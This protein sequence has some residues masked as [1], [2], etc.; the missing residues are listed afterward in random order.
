MLNYAL[1]GAGR[2]A[3]QHLLAAIY[4]KFN[5]VALVDIERTKCNNLLDELGL[6]ETRVYT[7]YIEMLK[8]EDLDLVAVATPNGTHFKIAKEVLLKKIN[9][10]IE[11]PVTISLVDLDNLVKLK[12]K[13]KLKVGVCHQNRFNKSIQK[14]KRHIDSGDLGKINLISAKVFWYRD[15]DYYSQSPWRGSVEHLDGALL[16][17][18]IHNIDLLLWFVNSNVIN[19][20]STTRNFIHPEIEMEDFGAAIIEFENSSVGLFEA[21][22]AAF[23]RN[24]EESLYIFAEKGTI[25][26]GG[27]SVN[28]IEEWRLIEMNEPVED[29]KFHNSELPENIYGN[30]HQEIYRDMMFSVLNDSEPY[31]TLENAKKSL[32]LILEIYGKQKI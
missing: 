11:K 27:Q 16:N 30:G 21:T 4:N 29:L 32:E 23:P 17:Q 9:L 22:T 3:K 12:N 2:I 15:T 20:K 6:N 10:I 13:N 7:D 26:I 5:I 28:I 14:I 24:L 1:I 31:I 25:K 18:S 8:N 19:V